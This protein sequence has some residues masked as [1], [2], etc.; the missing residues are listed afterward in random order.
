MKMTLFWVVAPC[1]LVEANLLLLYEP[2]I[3]L[4]YMQENQATQ[5]AEKLRSDNPFLWDLIL[6]L[7]NKIKAQIKCY[8]INILV[9]L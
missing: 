9:C 5:K 6:A 3:S 4:N 2:E 7:N 8:F 1:S